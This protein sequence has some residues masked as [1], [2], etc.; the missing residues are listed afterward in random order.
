MVPEAVGPGFLVRGHQMDA[1]AEEEQ[2][3]SAVVPAVV[4]REHVV[5]LPHVG[6]VAEIGRVE[7]RA[8]FQAGGLDED[9]VGEHVHLVVE[10]EQAGLGV[11]GAELALDDLAVLV[12][13]RRPV[14]E[15]GDGILGVVVQVAGPQGVLVLVFQLDQRSAELGHVLVHDILEGLAGQL[16]PVL[17]D[18]DVADGVADVRVDVPEGR[19]AEQ[20][21]VVV[22]EAGGAHHLAPAFAVPLDQLCGLGADKGHLVLRR[23]RHCPQGQCRDE[24]TAEGMHHFEN[25][26]FQI[27]RVKSQPWKRGSMTI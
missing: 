13:H 18:A 20:V 11:I 8:V 27:G 9:G 7:V 22:E 23:D 15:N 19:V 10:D 6:P 14:L 4:R 12:P 16:G 26:L 5:A 24:K 21:G 3:P 25:L 1:P 2:F 17:D